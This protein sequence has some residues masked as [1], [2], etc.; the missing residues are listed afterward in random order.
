MFQAS[1]FNPLSF[2]IQAFKMAEQS[3]ARSGYWR[4]FFYNMQKEALEKPKSVTR[5]L[6]L[7]E[8]PKKRARVTVPEPEEEWVPPSLPKLIYRAPP[9]VQP[10]PL[11][12]AV[13]AI[14]AELRMLYL[15]GST[16][17]SRLDDTESEN[18][19]IELLLLAA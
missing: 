7:V 4:L 1:S 8:P 13:Q 19:D 14:K 18:E 17:Q 15:V 2:S 6:K 3:S 9:V 5:K 16:L 11:I 12:P 10:N